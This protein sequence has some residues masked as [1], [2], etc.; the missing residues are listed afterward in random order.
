[1]AEWITPIF[2][3][4][5]ADVDFAL[6]KI[7]EWRENGSTDLY[8]LKGCLNVTDINR[9]ENDIQHL[10]DSLSSLYYF[11]HAISKE[12]NTSGLLDMS[13]ID[14]IIGNVR[15]I[16]SAYIQTSTAPDV[17]DTMLTFEQINSIEENL[18]LVKELIDAMVATYR[19][20]GTFEC[21][22]EW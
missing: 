20:C 18:F 8:E 7:R 1:M 22:E 10:S 16:I 11:P 5:Q 6:S 13:D 15:N 17:P 3:R 12:W 2:D 14:R 21:G 4:T 9:I 19:N